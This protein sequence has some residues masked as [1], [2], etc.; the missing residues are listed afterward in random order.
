MSLIRYEGPDLF[1]EEC[2][3]ADL[4]ATWG[5]PCYLY[6]KN[7]LVD[8]F[9]QFKQG[10]G[11]Q[12]HLIAYAVKANSNLAILRTIVALGG[13][14]DIV[15]EGELERVLLAGA[16]PNTIVFSGVGKTASSIERGLKV[17][18][19]CFNVESFSEIER[20]HTIAKTL[21][22]IAPIALRLNPDISAETHPYISTGL[23]DNKFGLSLSQAQEVCEK[24]EKMPSVSLIGLD[25]HLGSQ[26]TSLAPFIAAWTFLLEFADF[27]KNRGFSLSLLDVGG[28]LGVR[29]QPEDTPPSI[30]TYTKTLVQH[31]KNS[32]YTVVVEPGRS[33]IAESGLLVARCEYIKRTQHKTF[34][35]L[36]TGMTELLRPSLYGAWHSIIP[37]Q[38]REGP[39]Q[40]V[41]VVGPI[42]ESSDWLAVNRNL[43]PI[44]EGD[45]LA[46]PMVGAYG[47]SMSSQYNSRPRP[48]EIWV[49][50]SSAQLI[51]RREA[52]HDLWAHEVEI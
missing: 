47:F 22:L 14:F 7:T 23:K 41:D 35:I 26:I 33:L 34:M 25:C 51:R 28:G 12:S 11:N 2:R 5:T 50:G 18:I 20:I 39:V 49:D 30:S 40:L 42:C 32:P 15:S 19:R 46:I 1:I 43:P 52:F 16:N 8:A 24:L 13:G 31:F 17:G 6:S 44:F 9:K 21:G 37:V 36:D 48:P 27:C 45:H 29:Y 38:Q 10:L 3:V 4:V